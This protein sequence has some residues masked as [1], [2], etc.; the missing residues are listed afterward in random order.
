M[1]AKEVLVE[2]FKM[3]LFSIFMSNNGVIDRL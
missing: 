3:Q 1:N 2:S